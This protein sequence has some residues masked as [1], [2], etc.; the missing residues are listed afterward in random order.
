VGDRQGGYTRIVKLGQRLGDGAEMAVIE[1]VDFNVGQEEPEKSA[2]GKKKPAGSA[3]KKTPEK[4]KEKEKK[5]TEETD[6][7]KESTKKGIAKGKEKKKK[8]PK[9]KDQKS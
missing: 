7:A 3:R 1:L 9:S 2:S 6:S 4:A 8:E 5:K